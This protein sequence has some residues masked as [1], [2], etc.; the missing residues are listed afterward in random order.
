MRRS[1]ITMKTLAL[2]A[3]LVAA[4]AAGAC[5][6]NEPTAKTPTKGGTTA[7]V[8]AT[9]ANT[10]GQTIGISAGA[11]ADSELT[12]DAKASYDKGFQLWAAG[13]LAGAKAAFL[14]SASKAPKAGAPRYSL[15]CLSERLGDTQGALDAY[16]ASYTANPKYEIAMGAY[17][18]LLAET[19]HGTDA[20]QFL[21]GKGAA[22]SVRL[23]AYLAEVKSIEGDSPGCQNT[24][25]QALT[26]QPDFKD[27]MLVIA[28]DFYRNHRWDLAKYALQA[29]LDGANGIPPRDPGNADGLLL[30]ALIE[31]EQ[32]DRKS[33][34]ADFD[35]ASQKRPD[36]FEAYINLGEMKLEAGN[37]TEAQAPLEKAVKYSPNTALA[38]LDLGDCYRLLGR[39]GDAKSE[40]DKASSIDS[41]L[42]GVHYNLGLLYLFSANVPGTSGDNDRLAKA[43]Q[44]LTTFKSM[45]N[46]KT[47]G[48]GDDVDDL[49]STAKRKQN[50]LQMKAQAAAAASAAPPPAPASSTP[51][52]P[53]PPPAS[54][55][56]STSAPAPATSSSSGIVR[57]M[58]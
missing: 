31:R 35:Q 11:G 48:A 38:H 24:A 49:L 39:P 26:K 58:P 2:S 33:A 50:E 15:G 55:S 44:E 1:R 34:L 13:D 19:G 46:A 41:T 28:R 21:N 40:F 53:P 42:A 37:A 25:Q 36:L 27:A 10:A 47:K 56:G 5:G 20:E 4:A 45:R 52:A 9:V 17:A 51:A 18:V 16:R 12:G 7:V 23:M 6:G 3:L 54:S 43:V 32:G 14:D 29:I 22:D 30:R 8:G 57:D